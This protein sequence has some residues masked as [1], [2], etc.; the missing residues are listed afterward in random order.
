MKFAGTEP[1]RRS[2]SGTAVGW[3]VGCCRYESGFWKVA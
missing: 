1:D 3:S 2:L